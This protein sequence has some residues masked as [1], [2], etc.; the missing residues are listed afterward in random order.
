MTRMSAYGTLPVA[1]HNDTEELTDPDVFPRGAEPITV[2]RCMT[3]LR[4]VDGADSTAFER[5]VYYAL[6]CAYA[7]LLPRLGRDQADAIVQRMR[8]DCGV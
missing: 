8:V 3:C 4:P 1:L 2:P 6:N 7:W 5:G